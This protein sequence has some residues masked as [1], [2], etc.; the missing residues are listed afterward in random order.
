MA[1]TANE[2]RIST[3]LKPAFLEWGVSMKGDLMTLE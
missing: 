1:R 2:T 3:K